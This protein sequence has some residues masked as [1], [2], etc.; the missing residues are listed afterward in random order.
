MYFKNRYVYIFLHL[1]VLS[2]NYYE[3]ERWHFTNYWFDVPGRN[4]FG[5]RDSGYPNCHH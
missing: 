4:R 5:G 1:I 2:V 3:S